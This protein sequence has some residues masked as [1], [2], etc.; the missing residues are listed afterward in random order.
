M[1]TIVGAAA[2][3]VG[4]VMESGGQAVADMISG[5]KSLSK[6]WEILDLM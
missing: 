1:N 4:N 5:K 2:G 6:V 3:V